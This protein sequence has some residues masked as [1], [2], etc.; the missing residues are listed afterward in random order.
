VQTALENKEIDVAID[1]NW[2]FIGPFLKFLERKGIMKV[3]KKITGV[4]IRKMLSL[5][6]YVLLYVLKII[7]GI[8]TTRGSEALLGD[9]GAMNLIGFDVDSLKNGLCKRGDANQ[10]G[11]DYKKNTLRLGCIYSNR[12]Y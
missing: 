10:Y 7:V 1:T 12:Q 5:H 8:P 2:P 3:L 9:K 4:Q 6:T 11:S